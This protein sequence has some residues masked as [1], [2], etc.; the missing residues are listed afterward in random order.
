MRN[1][2]GTGLVPVPG[3]PADKPANTKPLPAKMEQEARALVGEIGTMSDLASQFNDNYSGD[4]RK[5]L[6]R[7]IGNVAGGAAPKST[8]DMA[9]WWSDQAMFDELP[10]RHDMFGAALTATEQK[11]WRDAA[12]NPGLAPDVI[13]KRLATRQQLSDKALGHLRSSAEAAGYNVKQ[14]DSIRPKAGD[15]PKRR[16]YNPAT[17][18]FE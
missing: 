18:D 15:Q 8:Q 5:S 3:G 13:R 11:A 16:K 9:R 1:A 7:Q 6:E 4:I 10:K 17:G 12:I 2:D 14:I